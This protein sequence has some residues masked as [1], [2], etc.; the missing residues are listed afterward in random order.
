MATDVARIIQN[1]IDFYDF[2]AK[3]IISVGAGGGQLVEYARGARRVIAV[4]SDPAAIERLNAALAK[5]GLASLFE[6][7]TADFLE[8]TLSADV[9][10]FEFCLHEMA[11]PAA[12]IAH[13][14][15][16]APDVVVIDHAPNS[17]WSFYTAEAEKIA[18]EWQAVEAAGTS[19]RIHHEA[20]QRFADYAEIFEKLK[21]LGPPATDRILR[22][23][24][25]HDFTIAMPYAI[26]LMA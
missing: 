17:E 7:I 26:A 6:T 24:D 9:V 15:A 21:G 5:A 3:E 14:K 25:A 22:F 2:T 8:T 23:R 18:A 4:D 19:R 1:L 16:M 20:I 10:L 12:A 13:A 11:D